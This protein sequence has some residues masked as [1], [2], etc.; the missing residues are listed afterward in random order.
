MNGSRRCSAGSSICIYPPGI[1]HLVLDRATYTSLGLEA[2]DPIGRVA[3]T[4]KGRAKTRADYDRYDVTLN[5]MDDKWKPGEKVYDRAMWC[6]DQSRWP[7]VE[8]IICALKEDGTPRSIELSHLNLG[9]SRSFLLKPI[10]GGGAA[11]FMKSV[12]GEGLNVDELCKH[13][14]AVVDGTDVTQE[15][16]EEAGKEKEMSDKMGQSG[17]TTETKTKEGE[18]EEDDDEGMIAMGDDDEDD[19]DKDNDIDDEGGNNLLGALT[20]D[21]LSNSRDEPLNPRDHFINSLIQAERKLGLIH[22]DIPSRGAGQAKTTWMD[23]VR[24]KGLIPP[25]AIASSVVE[26]RKAIQQGQAQYATITVWGYETSAVSWGTKK[27]ANSQGEGANSG[28][29]G[30]TVLLLPDNRTIMIQHLDGSGELY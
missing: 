25:A 2:G 29:N 22:L 1:L 7:A 19:E 17:S 21:S 9:G 10:Q 5:M 27:H 12:E 14:D 26:A 8:L 18:D 15:E 28:E 13:F 23:C 20:G 11:G 4:G 30:Y 6:L 3:K 24:R 16:G